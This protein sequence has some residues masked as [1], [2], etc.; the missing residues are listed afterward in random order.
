MILLGVPFERRGYIRLLY[1]FVLFKGVVEPLLSVQLEVRVGRQ[2]RVQE[3]RVGVTGTCL[4]SM[5]FVPILGTRTNRYGHGLLYGYELTCAALL[6]V[7]GSYSL[8]R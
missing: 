5:G 7:R 4:Q 1:L 8:F 6:I 2:D 3:V